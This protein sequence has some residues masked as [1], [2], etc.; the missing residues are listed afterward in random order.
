MAVITFSQAAL[1]ALA[2]PSSVV[3]ASFAVVPAMPCFSCISSIAVTTSLKLSIDKS[4]A[5]PI[6]LAYSLASA[7]NRSISF[8]EPE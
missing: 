7:I 5:C 8:F 2:E 6:D 1:V 3:I 4:P